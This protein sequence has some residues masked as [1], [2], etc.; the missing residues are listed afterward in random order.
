MNCSQNHPAS[1]SKIVSTT[2]SN[3]RH[4]ERRLPEYL[5]EMAM[6]FGE[7]TR[8]GAQRLRLIDASVASAKQCGVDLSAYLDA[9]LIVNRGVFITCYRRPHQCR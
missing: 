1:T 2:H 8:T 4:T 3:T 9:C 7:C 6:Y 5:V